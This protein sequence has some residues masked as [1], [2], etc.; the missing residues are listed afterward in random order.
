MALNLQDREDGNELLHIGF[1]QDFGC[2]AVGTNTGFRIYN[3][4]PFKETFRRDFTSGGIGVVE[5]LFRCNILALVGGGEMPRYPPNKVMIWDDHQNRNIGELSFRSPVKAVKLRRDRVVVVLERKIYVY[6]FHDLKLIDHIDTI[7]NPNG[8]CALCPN[9][10]NTILACP[11]PER[12]TVHLELYDVRKNKVLV[13]H[14][15][16][17]ACIN[18]NLDGTRLATASDKGTLI[19]VFDTSNYTMLQE[20]RRGMDRAR[21]HSIAFSGQ[22]QYVACS[23]DHGTVH[24]WALNGSNSNNNASGPPGSVATA[25]PAGGRGGE[26]GSGMLGNYGRD[27]LDGDPKKPSADENTKSTLSFFGSLVPSYFQSEWSFAQF[28]THESH[29]LV[30]FG[31]EPNTIIIVGADGSFWKASYEGGGECVEQA[32]C[33]FVAE[34]KMTQG[35]NSEAE[36]DGSGGGGGGETNVVGSDKR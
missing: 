24:V 13:A 9:S 29:T 3:C 2:F 23:S 19:R 21:I 34:P 32:Y 25:H 20:L 6:N 27:G 12:G 22:S 35:G 18:L 15:S 14:E 31:S 36:A 28:R 5:M 4:D 11:G 10:N 7:Q 1:N 30:A 17:L 33:K 16:D 26:G 8:L